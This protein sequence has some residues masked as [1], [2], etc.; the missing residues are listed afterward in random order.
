MT[1]TFKAFR[2]HEQDKKIVA[3]FEPLTLDDLAAGEVVIRVSHSDIN[4]KDAL[5]ATGAGKILRRYP[6]VGGIDLAGVVESSS[7]SRYEPGDSV[8]V[9][10]NALS[11][12]HDGGYAEYARVKGDWVIPMPP[13]LDEFTAMAIGTAGFTAGL[14]IHRMEHN[15][16][17][18]EKGPIVVTGATGGVGSLAIDMLTARGYEVVAVSGKAS[19]TDYLRSLGASRV[20][21]RQEINY[22][23]RP[24][25]SVQFA[26]AV[27][28]VGGEM[29][30]WLTR[31]VDFWGNIASIGLA[32]SAELKTTVMPFILRA[33]SLLGINTSTT[34]RDMRLE[35]WKRIATDLRPRHLDRIVTRTIAFDELPGEFP[36]YIQGGV[37]GRTVVKI[38][39]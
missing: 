8:L 7:D 28:N 11:E 14:A 26:G 36:A 6:L 19:S 12:T 10:G 15:G 39:D 33:V 25:E 37:V 27:D 1:S 3:R 22:G 34:P 35:V 31:T 29:L 4:Y 21:A 13:G 20:L 2:I 18:P 30:T 23:S 38:R 9:T 16:Q 32:G 24:L 5:A 17:T